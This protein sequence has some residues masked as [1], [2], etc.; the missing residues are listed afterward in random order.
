MCKIDLGEDPIEAQNCVRQPTLEHVRTVNLFHRGGLNPYTLYH[1]NLFHRV[2]SG[3]VMNAWGSI[4]ESPD[5]R[6][7]A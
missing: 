3:G 7:T 1:M 2:G 4:T 6:R 5:Q